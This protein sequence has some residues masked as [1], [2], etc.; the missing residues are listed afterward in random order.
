[1]LN[2]PVRAPAGAR[3]LSVG[4]QAMW[5]LQQLAPESTA[6][7]AGSAVVLHF[8]VDADALTGAVRR[9]LARHSLLGSVFRLVRGEVW[10][11]AA[12]IDDAGLVDLRD[13]TGLDDDAL[14]RLARDLAQVPFRLDRDLPVRISLL[15][16][17]GR[18]DVLV[19]TAHHI[20][21]DD[22]A[23]VEI[24]RGLLAE[25]AGRPAGET[26]SVP[27]D[28]AAD[29]DDY[30]RRQREYLAS[31]KAATAA[32]H[33]RGEFAGAE[34]PFD[35]G[36]DRPRPAVYQHTGAEVGFALPPKLAAGLRDA[37]AARNVTVFAYLISVFQVALY[38]HSGNTRFVVGYPVTQRTAHNRRSIGYFVNT[39]PLC[40][41]ID[42]D[43][44]LDAALKAASRKMWRGLMHRDYPVAMM[45]R[46]LARPADPGRAGP[47]EVMF[48][49]NTAGR[50]DEASAGL[51][52]GRLVEHAGLAVSR[53]DFPEQQ[54]QFDISVLV[55][56]HDAGTHVKFKY[57]TS[58][59]ESRTAERLAAGYVELLERA[60][61]GTLPER[62]RDLR[63]RRAEAV[64]VSS[65]GPAGGAAGRLEPC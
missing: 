10:R 58:L 49:L 36:A 14:R 28:D 50:G 31:P 53:F 30:V 64:A 38:R 65:T 41:Q 56:Q 12:Q 39:L 35:A 1:M 51:L 61:A 19:V 40:A 8:P 42:P 4:Q 43:D 18:D 16:R 45:P 2:Q 48:G 29:F 13:V 17:S 47:I 3:A 23:Q 27:G 52:P 11:V 22:V 57:N 24:L 26:E 32:A 60:V 33:W 44:G 21:V 25:Y 55:I 34:I 62:L 7:N 46:L 5:F 20:V 54:G 15:R 59:F 63:G 37:A 9:L 6:Y